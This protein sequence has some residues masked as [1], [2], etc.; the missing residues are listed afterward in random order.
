MC[1]R[2]NDEHPARQAHAHAVPIPQPRFRILVT[3]MMAAA[4]LME[5]MGGMGRPWGRLTAGL[6]GLPGHELRGRAC[7]CSEGTRCGCVHACSSLDEATRGWSVEVVRH[8]ASSG[9]TD[10]EVKSAR[11]MDQQARIELL[12]K[13]GLSAHRCGAAWRAMSG[14][15]RCCSVRDREKRAVLRRCAGGTLRAIAAIAVRPV[16]RIPTAADCST[17][18]RISP[19]RVPVPTPL[20]L[21]SSPSLVQPSAEEE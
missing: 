13:E 11:Q 14:I 5:L 1:S 3:V 20:D 19:A 6:M 4:M 2:L 8:R 18:T 15:A 17:R 10:A 7:S 9:A 21:V 12:Q 16:D